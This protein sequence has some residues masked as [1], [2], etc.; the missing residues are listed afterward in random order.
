MIEIGVVHFKIEN[1]YVFTFNGF[2]P[3][4]TVFAGGYYRSYLFV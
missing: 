2:F 3:A 4:F 1:G